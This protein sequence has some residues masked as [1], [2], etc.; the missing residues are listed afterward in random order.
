MEY[1]HHK[2]AGLIYEVI[3]E[4]LTTHQETETRKLISYLGLGWD[5]A[6]LSPQENKRWV[7]TA[8]SMQ[9]RRE[10]YQGSSERWKHYRPFLNGALDHFASAPE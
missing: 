1:F 6:C 3:Y 2:Y 7:G 4:R 8:S 10:V 9:V 5:D